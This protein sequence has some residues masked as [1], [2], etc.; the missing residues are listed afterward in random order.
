MVIKPSPAVYRSEELKRLLASLDSAHEFNKW[1]ND[2]E[3][4][5]KWNMFAGESI[6]KRQ[7]PHYYIERYG[8]N[9]LY[10]Y[11]HPKGFR[12]CYGLLK[13]GEMGV[14]P[15]IVDLMTHDEYTRRFGYKKS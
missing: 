12:S 8:V 14:C 2:M 4:A 15:L 6:P 10:R 1:I 7:I 11:D 13:N 3:I 5:L 9:A